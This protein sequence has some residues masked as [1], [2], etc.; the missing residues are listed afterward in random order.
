MEKHVS[1]SPSFANYF[2]MLCFG[3]KAMWKTVGQNVLWLQ[4]F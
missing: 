4:T 2:L 3:E 1:S